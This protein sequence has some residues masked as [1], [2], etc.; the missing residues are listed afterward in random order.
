MTVTSA[1]MSGDE[2]FVKNFTRQMTYRRCGRSGL[3]LPALALGMWQNFGEDRPFETQRAIAVRA[4]ER[5]V[6]H[7]DLANV[8]GPPPG[9]TEQTMRRLLQG[10][11]A[12]HR[13]ELVIAT[14]AGNPMWPGPY[15]TG[16]SR[17]HLLDALDQSLQRLGLDHVDIFYSHCPDPDTPLEETVGALASA[18]H[19]GKA[20]YV[21]VSSYAPARTREAARMLRE[22]GAPL[23]VHQPSY[24]LLDRWIE[25]ELLDVLAEEGVGCAVY[26]PLAQG[27]LS[28]RYL[29]R[30]PA[31]SRADR[32][33]FLTRADLTP[34]LLARLRA[35]AA[36]ACER[37]QTLAQLAL[38]WVLRDA[39]VTCAL[40]G[41]SSVAQ[42]EENLSALAGPP[43]SDEELAAID[44]H[45]APITGPPPHVV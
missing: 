41:A 13:D 44:R 5:G 30:V 28:D 24:S 32:G 37:R 16:G 3:R 40:V 45:A 15:G 38:A 31:G 11:L 20:R 23:L 26:S 22:L 43:L 8:Y 7:F 34:E 12:G 21:G 17:K 9:A 39:R 42:L 33:D 27:L 14:K 2:S 35:L 4:F 29:G 6:T 19:A 1:N 18:V 10:D 36:I 25:P